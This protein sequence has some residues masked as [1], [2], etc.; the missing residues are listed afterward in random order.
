MKLLEY[1][2]RTGAEYR[3]ENIEVRFSLTEPWRTAR[4]AILS[5]WLASVRF[6]LALSLAHRG[7]CRHL[8]PTIDVEV[9]LGNEVASVRRFR[10]GGRGWR[11]LRFLKPPLRKPGV[12]WRS[13]PDAASIPDDAPCAS[14]MVGVAECAECGCRLSFPEDFSEFLARLV[15][16]PS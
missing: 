5:A 16:G 10:E 14:I 3:S 15:V 12:R 8:A 1:L 13:N 2:K 9:H 6:P 7:L 11:E 4:Q